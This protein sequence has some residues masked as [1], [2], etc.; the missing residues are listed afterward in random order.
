MTEIV[1]NKKIERKIKG[2]L[3]PSEREIELYRS[4]FVEGANQIG[5]TGLLYQVD[6]D[7]TENMGT[8][9]YYAHFAPVEVSYYLVENPKLKQLQDLG[10]NVEDKS[11]KPM[12]CYLTFKDSRGDDIDPSEGAILEVSYRTTNHK[13][14]Y[15][16]EKF[17]IL[18]SK[19]DFEL[20]MF[21][22]NLVPHREL[23]KPVEEAPTPDDPVNENKWFN[24]ELAYPKEAP[25]EDEDDI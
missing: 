25:E 11:T 12:L 8:D 21:I 10:W 18:A 2:S 5:R 4:R 6:W 16:A 15:K 14:K 7:N 13:M 17:D 1:N 23:T 20:N 19:V 3:F 24:R 9:S 22:C